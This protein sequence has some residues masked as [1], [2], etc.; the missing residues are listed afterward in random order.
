MMVFCLMRSAAG[1]RICCKDYYEQ[2]ENAF[3]WNEWE[4][5]SL[6][7]AEDDEEWKKE[8]SAFWDVH[9]PIA[10]SV[11]DGYSYYAMSMEN[12]AIVYGCEPEFEECETVA[13]CFDDFM[14]KIANGKIRI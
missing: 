10:M 8:I 13:E 3:Q 14:E 9:F 11:K 5:I 12:G 2:S 6:E 7:S 1:I 4:R